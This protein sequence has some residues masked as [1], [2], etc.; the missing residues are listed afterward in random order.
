MTRFDT[1]EML[2]L[3]H[4]TGLEAKA[5]VQSLAPAGLVLVT[6]TD[7]SGEAGTF[8]VPHGDVPALCR[9][10]KDAAGVCDDMPELPTDPGEESGEEG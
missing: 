1:K 8:C 3:R 4:A 7:D 9:A 2:T 5:I 10:M 6:V